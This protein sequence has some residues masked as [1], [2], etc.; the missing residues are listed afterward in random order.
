MSSATLSTFK[1]KLSQNSSLLTFF[2]S[3]HLI[4]SSYCTCVKCICSLKFSC[5]YGCLWV[6]NSAK[7]TYNVAL[8]RPAYQSSLHSTS[9]ANLSTDGD[10]GP[11]HFARNPTCSHSRR[12]LNPWW[13]VDLG[14]PVAVYKVVLANR[15]DCCGMKNEARLKLIVSVVE[16]RR[17][18]LLF[19][20]N[21]VVKLECPICVTPAML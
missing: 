5:M 7:I 10:R 17:S 3:W 1:R 9:Y 16:C 6:V 20:S 12:E 14:R 8:N 4:R 2:F 15:G 11:H 13:A 19:L 18:S 21:I